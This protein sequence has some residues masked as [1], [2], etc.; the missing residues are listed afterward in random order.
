VDACACA[1]CIATY[2]VLLG[3]PD[4]RIAAD[5][6]I[7]Y[8][9]DWALAQELAASY[10]SASFDELVAKVWQS[11]SDVSDA[12]VQRRIRQIRDAHRKYQAEL[13]PEG[14]IGT[15]VRSSDIHQCLEV[16]SGT[17][18][19]LTCAGHMVTIVGIDVS[20]AWLVV[21][22]KRLEGVGMT[23]ALACACVER[24]PFSDGYFDLVA[25]FDVLEHVSDRRKMVDEIA[26]VSR[27]GAIG[28]YTT[29]NRFSLT[30][31]PHVGLLGVGFLP[32]HWM[33]PYVR[34]RN[35]MDYRHTHPLSQG[36]VQRLFRKNFICDICAGNIWDG[37][38]ASFSP[39]KRA[40]AMFYNAVMSSP[41][42]RR[43]LVRMSPFFQVVVQ[44]RETAAG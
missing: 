35:G 2:R 17:G 44:K 36:D 40:M 8:E 19:F 15:L 28:V 9:E 34:W 3:I 33:I 22:K 18:A 32:R 20:M 12:I 5:T 26:R 10:D 31:E 41:R 30:P 7:D 23:A 11:R 29:P 37:E 4:L 16:G 14:W 43:L 6:W 13:A 39:P 38:L 42:L 25:A 21:T 1:N 27:P 24:L